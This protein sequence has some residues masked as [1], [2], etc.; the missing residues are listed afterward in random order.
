S[1]FNDTQINDG[2]NYL[3]SNIF[4]NYMFAWINKEVTTADR[5]KFIESI[6][7]IFTDFMANRCN[8]R[9]SHLGEKDA[10][11]INYI[12]YMW[13]DLIP[14]H[15]VRSFSMETDKMFL[16]VMKRTIAI[17][18]IACQESA[19]RGLGYWH[20]NYPEIVGE[21]IDGY[22]EKFSGFFVK[23]KGKVM[24]K[25]SEQELPK[26]LIYARNARTGNIQ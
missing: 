16:D 4:S 13:W 23:K 21:I 11:S 7:R 8:E 5:K 26:I 17:N 2:L 19:L 24:L 10:H 15:P 18:N 1:K 14:I 12:C 3:V 9:L 6:Y 22:I 20:S 25:N